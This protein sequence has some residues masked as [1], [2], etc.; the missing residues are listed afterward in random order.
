LRERRVKIKTKRSE[1]LFTQAKQLI[2]GGVNSPVRAFTSVGGTPR[3]IKKGKGAYFWDEDGNKYID[4]VMSWGP[5][6]LGHAHPKVIQAIQTAAKNGTSFGAP[7]KYEIEMGE[8]ICKL[9]PSIEMV[10]MVNSG[11]EATMS[12]VR[13]ARAFTGKEKMIK[14]K[15][16]YHGHADGFLISAG[17]GVMTL[18]TPDSP[19]V[20]KNMAIDTLLAE[21][22]DLESVETVLKNYIDQV[23]AIIVE[24]V[25]GN[26]GCIPPLPE[27]LPGLR[28]L[29]DQ[30]GLLLIFDEVMTGF[31]LANGGA[32]ERFNVKPDLTT[33]GKIIGGGLPV[34]AFGG[35][36]DIMEMLAPSGPVYQAGTLS[37]NPL[38]MAAG[39][40]TLREISKKGFYEKLDKK[41]NNF[42]ESVNSIVK[43]LEISA[44]YQSVG[45]MGTLFFTDSP[46]TNYATAKE[47]DTKMYS[48]FFHALLEKGIYFAPS[49]FET[50]FLSVAHTTDDLDRTLESIYHS[51][52][53][54]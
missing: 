1:K 37:G 52:A 44:R 34:G 23:A 14:F 13:L 48:R 54:L 26:M 15:G 51:L 47:S 35:R 38:A 4:Y 7:T 30:Y 8:L 33:L 24:P 3:F 19:G 50:G 22:N 6:I 29:C 2:P 39:L 5:L 27:F 32:Q 43:K 40:V 28:K 36:R 20:T 21:Y 10:R 25:V 42:A 17:S 46:V 18:G 11:T 16:C 53:E 41:S 49:Q 9:V 12:A 31:R 45:S